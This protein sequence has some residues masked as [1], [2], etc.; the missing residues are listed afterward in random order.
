M[1]FLREAIVE[2]DDMRAKGIRRGEMRDKCWLIAVAKS[3]CGVAG[4]L[5]VQVSCECL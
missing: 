2:L 5:K 1:S 4:S 3:K